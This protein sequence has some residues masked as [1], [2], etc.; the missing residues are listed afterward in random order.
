MITVVAKID[1]RRGYYF[2]MSLQVCLNQQNMRE[3]IY[4]YILNMRKNKTLN[5]V[6]L[7]DKIIWQKRQTTGTLKK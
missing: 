7:S 6:Y 4:I 1:V 3:N 2:L 5:K